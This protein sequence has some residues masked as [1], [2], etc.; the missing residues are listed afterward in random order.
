M[1][2]RNGG[3]RSRFQTMALFRFH[4]SPAAAPAIRADNL[5]LRAPEAGDF[6]AWAKL[7]ALSRD[8]LTPWEPVW[9]ADD[10]TRP[11]FRRRL[12]RQAEEIDRDETYPFFL[13]RADDDVLL[14]GL[15]LGQIRRGVS[16]TATMGYWMGAPF[17]GKGYM[18]RAVRAALGHAFGALRLHRV[19]A[20]CVPSN[21]RSRRL[22]ESCGFR[23]E[24]YARAYLEIDGRWQDHLLFAILAT[25]PIHPPGQAT[26]APCVS[27]LLHE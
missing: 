12:R 5:Y 24:G 8:F 2:L 11:A 21:D 10:L 25:D 27:G 4:K 13:F 7:R 15:T 9:P 1:R 26:S 16:Q 14:G 17:A 22:L 20:A 23:R 3:A 19:E 6:E 18:S